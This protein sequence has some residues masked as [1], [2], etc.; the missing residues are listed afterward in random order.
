MYELWHIGAAYVVGTAAGIGIFRH[1]IREDLVSR[2]IDTL[3]D[4]DY[5]RT[6]RDDSGITHLYKWYELDDLLEDAKI[7][8]LNGERSSELT[9]SEIE[10]IENM[11]PEEIGQIF[12]ELIEEE[13]KSE[14][15]DTP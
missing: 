7:R 4:N 8:V 6:Y 3:V 1:V 15:D 14:K 13:R 12:D 2:A 11:D 10:I 9:E 5:V